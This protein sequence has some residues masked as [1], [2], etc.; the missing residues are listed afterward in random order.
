VAGSRVLDKGLAVCSHPTKTVRNEQYNQLSEADVQITPQ[1]V[2]AAG[3]NHGSGKE[4]IWLVLDTHPAKDHHR[5]G[6]SRST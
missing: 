5:C 4:V 3:Q 6:P 1:V 2:K